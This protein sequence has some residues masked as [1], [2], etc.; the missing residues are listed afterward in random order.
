MFMSPD[1][2]LVTGQAKED[3]IAQSIQGL[4]WKHEL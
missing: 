3:K 4:L 2:I 1:N